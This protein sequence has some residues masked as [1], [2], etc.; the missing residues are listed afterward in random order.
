M[1]DADEWM[2]FE[3]GRGG[4]QG[5]S[6]PVLVDTIAPEFATKDLRDP[7]EIAKMLMALR[8]EMY[9]DKN[10]SHGEKMVFFKINTCLYEPENKPVTSE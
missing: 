5:I 1:N 3:K 9:K 10:P 6:Q 2:D 7:I 8:D 4:P